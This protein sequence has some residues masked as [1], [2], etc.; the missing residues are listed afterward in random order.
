M[1]NNKEIFRCKVDGV[2]PGNWTIGGRAVFAACNY[3]CVGDNSKCHAPAEYK[4]KHKV[5]GNE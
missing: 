3:N 2:L 4:C 5:N 1:T